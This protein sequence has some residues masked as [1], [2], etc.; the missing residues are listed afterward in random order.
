[1]TAVFVLPP[2]LLLQDVQQKVTS[3]IKVPIDR[4]SHG[5]SKQVLRFVTERD[6]LTS[7]ICI[8]IQEYLRQKCILKDNEKTIFFASGGKITLSTY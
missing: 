8:Q 2:V 4:S 6:Y 1:M 5:L 7:S 3:R